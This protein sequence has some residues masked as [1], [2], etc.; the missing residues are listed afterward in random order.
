MAAI[1][2]I[3]LFSYI[4][5]NKKKISLYKQINDSY[6][7]IKNEILVQKEETRKEKLLNKEEVGKL[8]KEIKFLLEI[9]FK[10]NYATRYE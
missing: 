9:N 6:D 7:E 10:E 5:S 8:I 4:E 1:V 3:T 2:W